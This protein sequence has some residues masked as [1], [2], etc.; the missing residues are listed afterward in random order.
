[1][2]E[3]SLLG[4]EDDNDNFQIA[5]KDVVNAVFTNAANDNR[6]YYYYYTILNEI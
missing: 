4:N 6:K 5:P 2:S 3:E 1:M